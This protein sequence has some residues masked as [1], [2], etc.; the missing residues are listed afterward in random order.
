MHLSGFLGQGGTDDKSHQFQVIKSDKE[1]K[2]PSG[3]HI[4]ECIDKPNIGTE[5]ETDSKTFLF[6]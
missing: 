2:T 6:N 3:M 5:V 1:N 4:N